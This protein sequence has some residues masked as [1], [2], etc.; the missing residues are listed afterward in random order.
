MIPVADGKNSARRLKKE[1]VSPVSG[2]SWKFGNQL[3]N[4]SWSVSGSKSPENTPEENRI[5]PRKIKAMDAIVM[6]RNIV[7]EAFTNLGDGFVRE[8]GR[9]RG[10]GE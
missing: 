7:A 2:F 4:A 10:G 1:G 8:R 3:S 9:E 6:N 5:S